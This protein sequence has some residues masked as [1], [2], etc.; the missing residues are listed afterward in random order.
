[1]NVT[2]PF[3]RNDNLVDIPFTLQDNDGVAIDLT[4]CTLLFKAQHCDNPALKFSGAMTIVSA[5]AG[6]CKYTA[7]STDFDTAGD[8]QCEIQVTFGS[9]QVRT[10]NNL[11]VNV[12]ADL[13]A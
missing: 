5:A 4:G 9:G 11:F 6:T 13:P 7:Q 12:A 8:Y 10:Y 1:M 2:I 3:V